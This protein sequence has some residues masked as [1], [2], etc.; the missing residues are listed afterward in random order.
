MHVNEKVFSAAQVGDVCFGFRLNKKEYVASKSA[1]LYTLC[2]E[3]T[4][5]SLFY[6]DRADENK[7]FAIGFKTLPENDTGVFHILE[8]SVL[9]GSK[10]F[11]VKEPFV[12]MLQSSMQTFLNALT[13]SD[14]TLY[15]VA[16]RNEQD[17]FN[18][19]KV[20]LDA[21]FCPLIYERPEIFM[22]EGWH[23]EFGNSPCYNGVV[24]NEMK[25]V[26]ADVESQMGEE[27][28][29]LLY[30]DNSYG[31][32]SGG[33]PE[34]IPELSY[35]QFIA[36]H[37]RFYHPSNAC[38]FLDGRMDI[39]RVLAY[40]DEEYL[41]RYEYRAPDF[42]FQVQ[43]PK[44]AQR[45][46]YYEAQEGEEN[47]AHMAVGKIICS[48][49][50]TEKIFAAKI[51]ADYL[52]F[53]NEAPL[54]KA[55]LGNNTAQSVSLYVDNGNFQPSI[56]LM[57]HNIKPEQCNSVKSFLGSQMK[58][59]IAEGLDQK[60]LM[61]TLDHFAFYQKEISEPYGIS[62]AE[63]V[64]SSWIYGED[65]ITALEISNIITDLREKVS[66]D[67]FVTLLEELLGNVEEM[68]YL[69]ALPS[70][71][72]G[73]EEAEAENKRLSETLNQ[74]SEVQRM[75]EENAFEKMQQWQ[76]TP[77]SEDVLAML[78]HL[79]LKDVPEEVA[80]VENCFHEVSGVKVM[81]TKTDTNGIVYF[82]LYFDLSDFTLE[83]LRQLA[84]LC[85]FIDEMPTERSS[86]ADLQTKIRAVCGRLRF[87]VTAYSRRDD[88][89]HCTPYL[90][91]AVSALKENVQ[92]A[93]RLVEEILLH[94]C[95]DD[96][97]RIQ[98]NLLQIDYMNKQ[99]MISAGHTYAVIKALASTTKA[100]AMGELMAG[101]SSVR[102]FTDFVQRFQKE[103]KT[104]IEEFH[105]L[106]KRACGRNRMFISYGGELD[107]SLLNGLICTLPVTEMGIYADY[108]Q[109]DNRDC[110]IEIPG[111]VG[112]SALGG[113]IFADGK[114]YAGSCEVLA[115]LLTYGYLWNAV[116]VQGGAYGT[117]M[118]IRNDGAVYCYSYRDPN[119]EHTRAAFD[120]LADYLEE[121][122]QEGIALDDLIIGTVN[123]TDPLLSPGETCSLACIRYFKGITGET[124]NQIRREILHTTEDDL[125]Q[126]IGALRAYQTNGKFCAVGNAESVKFI[127]Q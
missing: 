120:G 117:R 112:F 103:S 113:S 88:P 42:A 7:T 96:V 44:A 4:K 70:Y 73:Q 11:P 110:A 38:I 89:D 13:Y 45:T 66:T 98:D 30:P 108:P 84:V 46:I 118:T 55:F 34:H 65:P 59:I 72:K 5:T 101:E 81:E 17:L 123:K 68:T 39:D 82:N 114:R 49:K 80:L 56:S 125:R 90:M 28:D 87:D 31:F 36:T 27:M 37:R 122:L 86:T 6:F 3:K 95:Y 32:V 94:G 29:R 18:L 85:S 14:M 115:S 91:V 106:I 116:R 24:F 21:V 67:Y 9:N 60:A 99:A 97:E 50:E 102:W 100:D 62:L 48:H 12:S 126:W 111:D 104:Y 35:E 107:V 75:Q 58:Q 33:H 15:P 71:T 41:C 64:V 83:E 20:Y 40:I 121:A 69:I 63:K 61:A 57:L 19:M 109:F 26:F 25:G 8:H 16:S 119:L 76:Q 23:Y 22:Q 78:P 77:D 43:T 74:W 127:K 1:N 92:N 105:R 53:S 124:V 54:T 52:T 10:K 51:L 2:H 47:L 79:S 93:L